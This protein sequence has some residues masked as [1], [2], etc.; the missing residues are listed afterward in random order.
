MTEYFKDLRKA[1]QDKRAKNRENSQKV[2]LERK[3]PF[4]IHNGGAHLIV[5]VKD[6][7]VDFWPGTGKWVSRTGKVGRG[8]FKLIDHIKELTNDT[9]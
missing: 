8:V 2:L 9:R 7:R 6:L 1:G 5:L 3:I 4:T